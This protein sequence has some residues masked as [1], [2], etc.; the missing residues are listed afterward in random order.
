ML[1]DT[2]KT[3]ATSFATASIIGQTLVN[4]TFDLQ[5]PLYDGNH[6]IELLVIVGVA[7]VTATLPDLDEIAKRRH[8]PFL[9]KV[10]H[11]GITH[12]VWP[13]ILLFWLAHISPELIY[14]FT[15]GLALG[16]T[17]HL[18]G[19][20]FSAQGIAWF[21]PFQKYEQ[22]GKKKWVKHRGPFIK[23]YKVGQK[24]LIDAKYY[25]YF[26]TFCLFIVYM[27]IWS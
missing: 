26:V 6:I 3:F 9:N 21:Y 15:Y 14:P 11:R 24:V 8:I 27:L 19:D 12:S 22:Y 10:A 18:V 7:Y 16:Y 4:K 20:A 25:W 13:L 1:K 2:H 5:N 23:L 17:S